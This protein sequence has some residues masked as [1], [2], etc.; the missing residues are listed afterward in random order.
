MP[1]MD[2]VTLVEKL[3]E[4]AFRGKIMV[5]SAGLTPENTATYGELGVDQILAKPITSA[6]LTRII[7]ETCKLEPA[8]PAKHLCG[9]QERFAA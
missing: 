6:I 8:H 4:A 9:Q 5:V 7:E 1:Q 3:K 2:G